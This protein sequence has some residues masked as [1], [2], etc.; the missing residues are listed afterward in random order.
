VSR[1]H[2]QQ[3]WMLRKIISGMS[4]VEGMEFMLNGLKN[5]K[6]NADFFAAMRRSSGK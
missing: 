3:I 1:D 4:P 6:N 5:S 2:L